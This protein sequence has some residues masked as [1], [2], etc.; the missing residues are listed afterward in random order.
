MKQFIIN[1]IFFKNS[2]VIFGAGITVYSIVLNSELPEISL[3]IQM[4]FYNG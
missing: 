3:Q 1:Y 4:A 2:F